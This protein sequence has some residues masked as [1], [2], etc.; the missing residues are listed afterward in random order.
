M[1]RH[2]RSTKPVEA[3]AEVLDHA[4]AEV[5][6]RGRAALVAEHVVHQRVQV[7]RVRGEVVEA[8]GREAGVAEAAQVGND[9][10]EAGRASGSMLRHQIRLVSGQPCTSSS[11]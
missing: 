6:A 1:N 4:A 2:W 11:G 8:V 9:H 3:Q 10:L 7:A 5:A